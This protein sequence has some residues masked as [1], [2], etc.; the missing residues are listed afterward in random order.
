M[1]I[2]KTLTTIGPEE[3]ELSTPLVNRESWVGSVVKFMIVGIVTMVVAVVALV[4]SI[5]AMVL[6]IEVVVGI[7]TIVIVVWMGSE[8]V[9]TVDRVGCRVG[10]LLLAGLVCR[11]IVGIGMI[12]PILA[13][14]LVLERVAFIM[15]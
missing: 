8:I 1:D 2:H 14:I 4:V 13:F 5:I 6:S 15:G 3:L 9:S 10:L 7:V 11:S 12:S